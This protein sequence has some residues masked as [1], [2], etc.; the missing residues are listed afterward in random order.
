M[1]NF[2]QKH[3]LYLEKLLKAQSKLCQPVLPNYDIGI[4]REFFVKEILRNHLPS[5][6]EISS[7]A[8][9]DQD[10]EPTDQI[11]II[12][13][14]PLSFKINIGVTNYFISESVFA[15]I[16]IKSRLN[17][18]DFKRAIEKFVKV[19]QLSRE[20][21]FTN[22]LGAT[23]TSEAYHYNTIGT[24]LFAYR[25]YS[26][27]TC[28]KKIREHISDNWDNRPEVIYSLD[29]KYI[30]IRNDY[31]KRE[32]FQENTILKEQGTP[33]V[34]KL[35]ESSLDG[36]LIIGKNCLLTLITILSKRIQCNYHLYPLLHN[37]VYPKNTK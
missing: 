17:D 28:V 18:T 26:A 12:I 2:I 22:M 1:T 29:K 35:A 32:K 19:D 8:I 33:W 16:E 4:N 30:L 7:G 21:L 6:C 37:Y 11:D 34:Y 20:N 36:Y 15:A 10:H 27:K 3:F 9:F 31:L 25:S 14:H 5:Y 13:Y 24:V 23:T